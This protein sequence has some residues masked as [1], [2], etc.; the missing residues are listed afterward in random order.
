MRVALR[1]ND[2]E[3]IA[4]G[5]IVLASMASDWEWGRMLP[6]A[7]P[8]GD[9][10]VRTQSQRAFLSALVARSDIWIYSGRRVWFEKAGLPYDREG[11]A[12][13]LEGG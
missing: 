11:C 12:R 6:I 5:A 4:T 8:E 13:R 3:R 10:I 1:V 2:F 9:G 7:F